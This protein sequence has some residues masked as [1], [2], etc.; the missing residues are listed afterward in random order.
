MAEVCHNPHE[1][2][3]PDFATAEH[4]QQ[5]QLLV[6]TGLSEEQAAAWDARQAERTRVQ[7]ETERAQQEENE[8]RR[9]AEEELRETVHN[10]E[11]KK[12]KNKFAPVVDAPLPI[13]PVHIPSRIALTRMK[14][15]E[16]IEM[17]Y[18]TNKGI[19]AAET[20]S[21]RSSKKQQL[22]RFRA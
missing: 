20:S 18:F 14:K 7:L 19:R 15:G 22:L 21:T 1:A 9:Q 3:Q 17:W 16:Y 4:A 8:R 13:G 2:I 11:R 5:R 6:D 12:Y 10:E